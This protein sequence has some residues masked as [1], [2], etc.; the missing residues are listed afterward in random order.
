M[1]RTTDRITLDSWVV[2]PLH[3]YTQVDN[4]TI[5]SSI[6]INERMAYTKTIYNFIYIY[7]ILHHPY[8]IA[9]YVPDIYMY[10]VLLLKVNI[11]LL[12]TMPEYDYIHSDSLVQWEECST[13]E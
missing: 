12:N 6:V 2:G 13:V 9:F 1:E 7:N 10:I 8:Q 11:M 4:N 5:S 3:S